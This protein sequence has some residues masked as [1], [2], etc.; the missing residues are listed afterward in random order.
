MLTSVWFRVTNQAMPKFSNVTSGDAPPF[1]LAL[2]RLRVSRDM[3]VLDL[4]NRAGV[5][6]STIEAWEACDEI[7]APS[8]FV[9]LRNVCFGELAPYRQALDVA[10]RAAREP[11]HQL[12]LVVAAMAG[13]DE[14]QAAAASLAT[15][16]A[17][18]RPQDAASFGEALR[19]ARMAEGMTADELGEILG[20]TGGAVRHWEA[21]DANPIMDHHQALLD[22]LPVLVECMPPPGGMPR[23]IPKPAGRA[24]ILLPELPAQALAT[25]ATRETTAALA[26]EPVA[27][28]PAPAAA[29]APSRLDAAGVAYAQALAALAAAE[30]ASG[31]AADNLDHVRDAAERMVEAAQ[32]AA[33]AAQ[34]AEMEARRAMTDRLSELQAIAGGK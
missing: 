27:M 24:P 12:E 15:A 6:R 8:E 7:P 32:A 28:W 10:W 29:P 23:R 4:A 34:A 17:V 33:D 18:D 26:L 14:S 22:L 19:R 31:A 2:R 5:K 9:R 25:M 20:V 3:S 11:A 30:A 13:A 21:G 1:G 16:T